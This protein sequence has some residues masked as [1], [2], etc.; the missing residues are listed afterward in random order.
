MSACEQ[1]ETQQRAEEIAAEVARRSRRYLSHTNRLQLRRQEALSSDEHASRLLLG[2]V[3][4]VLRFQDS[5][6]AARRLEALV[7]TEGLPSFAGRIDRLALRTGILAARLWPEP[8][9]ALAKSRLR[10]A[11]RA[12]I[13][14]LSPQALRREVRRRARSG[15]RCNLNLLGEAIV[16]EAEAS[17]RLAALADLLDHPFVDYVSVKI[18]AICAQLDPLGFEDSVA[19][20]ASALQR[21]F[22][23][24]ASFDPPKFVSLDMEDYRDFELSIAAFE[25][26]LSA[27][28]L[29]DLEAGIALQAYLPDSYAAMEELCR[30]ARE[31][32][33]RG[34]GRIKVRLVKGANLALER[35]EAE[36]RGW[37]LAP[38]ED[39]ASVDAH[40]KALLDLAIAEGASGSMRI[41]VA[42][43]NLFEVGW[44]M[45][46]SEATRVPVEAE[47]LSGMANHHA[48][49]L[50]AL[51]TR[52]VLYRPVVALDDF[53][54]AV[55]YLVRRLDENTSPDN[56]LA[57]PKATQVGSPEWERQRAQFRQAVAAHHELKPKPRRPQRPPLGSPPR[58]PDPEDLS[59]P[60][61]NAADTDFS[62]AANRAWLKEAVASYRPPAVVPAQ[63]RG[64]QLFGPQ[65]RK[66]A[67]P[68]SAFSYEYIEISPELVDLAIGTAIEAAEEWRGRPAEERARVLLAAAETMEAERGRAIAAMMHDTSK[69]AREADT[70]VSEAIDFA[71]Y[72]ARSCLEL[73]SRR[74]QAHL[75][76]YRTVA[77]V[78]PWNFPYSI[79]ANGVF[80]ALA[81]GAAVLLKP[82]PEAV[83]VAYEL[84]RQC[85]QA[86]VPPEVLQF[87]PLAEEQAGRHLICHSGL[88]AVVLTGSWQTGRMFA[89]W[90]PDLRLHAETS[91][92]NAIVVTAAADWDQAIHDILTSAFG[93]AGQK[94]SAASLLILVGSLGRSKRFLE[95]L[96]DATRTLRVGS[97]L[98]LA[99]QCPPLIRPPQGALAKE[100]GELSPGESWLVPPEPLDEHGILWR[101]GI[102]M[103]VQ[104]ASHFHLNECF[105]PLLGIMQA[106]DLDEALRLQ[107][108]TGYGLTGGLFSLDP[109]EVSYWISKAEAGNLYVNRP[110]TGAIVGRQPFGG[111]KRSVI[112]STAKVGG[113]HYLESLG[114]WIA[115]GKE[116]LQDHQAQIAL[117][118]DRWEALRAGVELA[119][120]RSEA[121]VARLVPLPRILLR[122]EHRPQD[123]S[124]LETS[125]KVASLTG[126]EP[127]VSVDPGITAAPER[128]VRETRAAFIRRL[129]E[130]PPGRLRLLG[131]SAELSTVALDA[132]W[133]LDMT[134]PGASGEVELLHW[135]RE[136]V[137]SVSLHRYGNLA[138]GELVAGAWARR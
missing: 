116:T 30:F 61:R 124:L 73:E 122:I 85:W 67:V 90:R 76:A 126:I 92:K 7:R 66:K 46:L 137:V 31:R 56:F 95:R 111:W 14:G 18:S 71:R 21:L 133:E 13:G 81:S 32:R 50:A 2:L 11:F 103:G 110:I 108:G 24:A 53:P 123:L 65:T 60:F 86:G 57:H 49:A 113:P 106:A 105:G 70:E 47:M 134:E 138:A 15:I 119:G 36:L 59:G 101:P 112:G 125:L 29:S 74:G 135:A 100:L 34:G 37:P 136:Q 42:S 16:G 82:A 72:Y 33:A 62:L 121:N 99:T 117:A 91:G 41:G 118:R 96:A 69:T 120:L 130:G 40:Y 109:D 83:L 43:H 38:F 20:A 9:M 132:G 12:V 58:S 97:P 26:A 131:S 10:L 94:C 44:A 84:A 89:E 128:A 52:V 25:E 107:N 102:K 5:P 19:R 104:E 88:D 22:R 23:K 64:E 3:D 114:R 6:Q 55:A 8:V 4:Q 54:S 45:A 129:L 17:R 68:G 98:D 75:V 39:K 77:V 35:T 48:R 78:P 27:S 127:E 80:S 93:H 87:I 115:S 79:P 63:V 51:G 28:D 1:P